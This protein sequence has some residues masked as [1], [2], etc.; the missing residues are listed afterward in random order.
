MT[1]EL[2]S[3]DAIVA[4]TTRADNDHAAAVQA[5]SDALAV[6]GVN[7][8]YISETTAD[9]SL[10]AADGTKG[11]K[12]DALGNLTRLLK[13][14]ATGTGSWSPIG[15][16]VLTIGSSASTTSKGPV[17]K[18]AALTATVP[19]STVLTA[20]ATY[21]QADITAIIAQLDTQ[22]LYVADLVAKLRA[23]GIQT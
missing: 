6:A 5:T 14:G 1:I 13:V 12:L 23:A 18:S 2:L 10:S 4:L 17:L 19:P 22:R 9:P 15:N 3:K 21:T 7:P 8:A 11:A 20:S 16:P